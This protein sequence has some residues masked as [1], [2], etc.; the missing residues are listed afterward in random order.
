[1]NLSKAGAVRME[2]DEHRFKGE[3]RDAEK[4]SIQ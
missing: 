4:R 2:K 3:R 1:M